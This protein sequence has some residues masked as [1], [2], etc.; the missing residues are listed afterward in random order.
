[1]VGNDQRNVHGA[2]DFAHSCRSPLADGVNLWPNHKQTFAPA[3]VPGEGGGG[4]ALTCDVILLL[5]LD[6]NEK[7]TTFERP[8]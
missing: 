2:V 3:V 1:M 7:G 5:L 4:G 6:P 8:C